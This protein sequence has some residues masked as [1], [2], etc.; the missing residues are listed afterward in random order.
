MGEGLTL[1][2]GPECVD[3]PHVFLFRSDLRPADVGG[4]ADTPKCDRVNGA[5]ERRLNTVVL[6]VRLAKLA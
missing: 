1:G 3:A 6:S 4:L 2:V 5:M